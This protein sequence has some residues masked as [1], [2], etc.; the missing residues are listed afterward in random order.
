M[1]K[2]LI[3]G[4]GHAQLDLFNICKALGY[5]II[6]CS[7][8]EEGP[9]L[10]LADSFSRTD[11]CDIAGVKAVAENNSVDVIYSVGSDFAMPTVCSVS[12]MLGLPHFVSHDIAKLCRVKSS[13]RKFLGKDFVGNIDYRVLKSVE[14]FQDSSFPLVMKPVDSQGQ[15]GV[16]TVRTIDDV[17]R[18]LESTKAFSRRGE[19]VIETALFGS[20]V[21]V[22]TYSIANKP[23]AYFISD[24][25]SW[26]QFDGGL[27]RRHVVPSKFVGTEIEDKIVDLVN[28]ILAKLGI[29]DGPCYFQIM[30]TAGEPYVIEVSPRL[31]GC[32]L[33][34]L[35]DIY[36]SINILELSVEHLSGGHL[37]C[38]DRKKSSRY[39][40]DGRYCLEFFYDYP[41][42]VMDRGKFVLTNPLFVQWYYEN[43][44]T[45]LPKNGVFEKCGYQ[46]Y[47]VDGTVDEAF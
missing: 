32:H 8:V 30:I 15:R 6:A 9:G 26:Q 10:A 38:L 1:A 44:E 46:I 45:I 13:L 3:L 29:S 20:E 23:V 28:S 39:W 41:G 18:Y 12:R 40:A 22:N 47:F 37:R 42:S 24:R 35:I 7:N 11:I 33:W 16:R 27:V 4:I 34:R 21:S 31:D 5:E 17:H 25:L 19:V 2:I 14:D 36:S 43:G